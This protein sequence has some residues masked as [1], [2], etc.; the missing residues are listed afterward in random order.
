MAGEDQLQGS[1]L[2]QGGSSVQAPSFNAQGVSQ[3]QQTSNLQTGAA[4]QAMNQTNQVTPFG[5]LT[6]NQSGT[7]TDPGTGTAVP[8]YTATTSL[9]PAEQALLTQSQGIQNG[10][11]GAAQSLI[12]Q[13]QRNAAT[14]LPNQQQGQNAAYDELMARQNQQFGTET[15]Q[16]QTQL[17]NQGINPGT[18]AY[19]NAFL[20]LNQSEVDAVNQAQLQ[21][22]NLAGQNLQQAIAAQNAPLQQ[23]QALEGQGGAIQNPTLTNTPTT[24]VAPTNTEAPQIAAYQGELG[25]YEQSLAANNAMSGGLFGLGGSVLGGLAGNTGLMNGLF[26]GGGSSGNLIATLLANGGIS[27]AAP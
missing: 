13:V 2:M 4:Q 6:Y 3:Q 27:A 8:T 26:G 25:S 19:N 11:L 16:L 14:P 23:L 15:S 22:S 9:S 17:A 7:Y 12:P 21:S 20:P 18:T 10:Q 1:G 24:T 5:S